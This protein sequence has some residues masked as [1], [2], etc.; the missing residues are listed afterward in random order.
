MK[1]QMVHL[2]ITDSYNMTYAPLASQV[3]EYC[4][5]TLQFMFP[6]YI[7]SNRENQVRNAKG[8]IVIA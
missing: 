5:F 4:L 3:I 1:E 8:K 2:S 7:I 6:D